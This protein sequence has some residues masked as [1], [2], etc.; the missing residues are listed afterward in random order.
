MRRVWDSN[1]RG[2][3]HPY[4]VSS[5]A[6]S[7]TQPTLRKELINEYKTLQNS[8]RLYKLKRSM[9]YFKLQEYV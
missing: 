3:H 5:E 6:L 2:A 9:L 7:A 4:L 1:P 8:A